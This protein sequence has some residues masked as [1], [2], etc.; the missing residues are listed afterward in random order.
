VWPRLAKTPFFERKWGANT[1]W[2][3]QKSLDGPS[4]LMYLPRVVVCGLSFCPHNRKEIE[5]NRICVSALALAA[6]AG[7]A[8]AQVTFQVFERSGQTVA[9]SADALLEIGVRAIVNGGPALGGF[10]FN[11]V[12][13]DAES[14]GTFAYGRITHFG[15]YISN[16][17]PWPQDARQ[18][19]SG[20]WGGIPSTYSYLAGINGQFQGLINLSGG[21]FTNGPTNEIGLIA[22]AATGGALLGVPGVDDNGNNVPDTAPGN[23]TGTST[24]GDTAILPASLMGPYF[25]Q[26]QYIDV[27]HSLYTVSN[28][29]ARTIHFDLGDVGAQIFSQLLYN[30]G[31]WGAE[32]S[33]VDFS[34]VTVQGL[35]IQVTPTP[36]SV[37]LLGLG[38]LVVARRRRA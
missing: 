22:G 38:G 5:M 35:D 17:S 15:D 21:T 1:G 18:G 14:N 12:T 26:G 3:A 11:L 7:A 32:N 8:N 13:N 27:Y 2:N 9:S 30:N 29:S 4:S 25:G 23:A 28:F 16:S 19:A 6:L 20:Y 24:N 31:A 37:A 36:A 10:N 34:Q 33:T